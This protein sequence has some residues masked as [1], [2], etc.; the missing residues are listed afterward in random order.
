MFKECGRRTDDGRTDGRT[1]DGR[2]RPTYPISS[3][4]SLRLWWANKMSLVFRLFRN[5]GSFCF[6]KQIIVRIWPENTTELSNILK[7]EDHWSCIAHLSAEDMLKSAFIEEKK[8]KILNLSDVDQGQWMT[9]DVNEWPWTLTFDTHEASC[10]H[11]VD[12]IYQLLYNRLQLF[13][14]KIH[15]FTVFSI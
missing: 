15:C 6:A 8:L 14:K 12:C 4:M 9:L 2:R 5:K 10:T 3:P 1:D 13:L 11:L 7:P